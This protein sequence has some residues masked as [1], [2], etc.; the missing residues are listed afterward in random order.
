MKL[1]INLQKQRDPKLKRGDQIK[2]REEKKKSKSC[3]W[4]KRRKKVFNVYD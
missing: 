2:L 1:I 3:A 4:R